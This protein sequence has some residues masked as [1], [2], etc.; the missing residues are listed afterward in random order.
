MNFSL[1]RKENVFIFL[2]IFNLIL[3]CLCL[4]L[5][6]VGELFNLATGGR[7]YDPSGGCTIVY[8]NPIDLE[9]EA[10]IGIGDEVKKSSSV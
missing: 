10:E 2:N 9:I 4:A 6:F 5:F 8:Q 1:P 3:L 7:K